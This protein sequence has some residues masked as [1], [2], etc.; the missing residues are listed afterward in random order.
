[1]EDI[2]TKG[3]RIVRLPNLFSKEMR[4]AILATIGALLICL[5]ATLTDRVFEPSYQPLPLVLSPLVPLGIGIA[6]ARFR[7]PL[8]VAIQAVVGVGVVSFVISRNHGSLPSDL[9]NGLFKGASAVFGTR[10]PVPAYPRAVALFALVVIVAAI[11][12]VEM[13]VSG[14][15]ASGVLLAPTALLA[16]VAL[17]ASKA[18]MPSPRFLVLFT[19]GN[20]AILRLSSLTRSDLPH[21]A[22]GSAQ[23]AERRSILTMAI[24]G[25]TAVSV[26]IVPAMLSG[27][28]S[29]NG[30]F[31]P[32]RGIRDSQSNEDEIS[33]LARVDVW[34]DLNPPLE[35][36]RT[37]ELSGQR[38]RIAGLSRYDGR[39]WM[40]S[41][42]F[43]L[44]GT[45][46]QEPDP[47]GLEPETITVTWG[48]LD[49]RWLP[50]LDHTRTLSVDRRVKVD[51]GLGGFLVADI[52]APQ[53]TYEL[54]VQRVTDDLSQLK[55]TFAQVSDDKVFV[56]GFE[57]PEALVEL[58]KG[59]VAG[60]E[61][62]I[63]RANALRDF[64]KKDY[65]LD[66]KVPS[67]HSLGVLSIFLQI[68]KRGR[69]EQFVAGY[70]L[71]AA[72]IGLPVRIAVGFE[73]KL[74]PDGT[75]SAAMSADATAWPEIDYVGTGWVPIDVVPQERQDTA[76]EGQQPV[77]QAPVDD[78]RPPPTT[79]SPPPTS[80]V[81]QPPISLA[82][83]AEGTIPNAAKK[84]IA[85]FG[86]LLLAILAY[87][88]VIFR[89]KSGRRRKRLEIDDPERRTT[90]A[91][92]TS[93]DTLID[94]GG[95][96]PVN[97]TD[98]ELVSIGAK[99]LP[100]QP[101]ALGDLAHIATQAVY[102]GEEP[103]DRLSSAAWE[104]HDAF[105]AQAQADAGRW[106]W[107]KA[108]MSLRSL[109]RG[110]PD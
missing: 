100:R 29:N 59:V 93:V 88:L 51:P 33:P 82:S 9:V 54:S 37:T 8:R 56:D 65:R 110:L 102:D 81:E 74:T 27:T 30:R 61:T 1:M 36:F 78:G 39:S 104:K 107:F 55:G 46:I 96:A 6:L 11:V 24:L 49:V 34:R 73:A 57:V 69:S 77:N 109:R 68:T 106:R 105:E 66:T 38:W 99:V 5:V 97:K 42:N 83:G 22:K 50:A 45:R 103:D 12:V 58:A 89:L 91:F 86:F 21:H 67:G 23:Q 95:R 79:V 60:A 108:R 14:K 98:R 43:Q 75:A 63:E 31:D 7:W 20:L 47:K 40:P 44:A 76:G 101:E 41:S 15:Y 80:A 25:I 10:W 32:R 70:A 62:D 53:D 2:W 35:M 72:A 19:L 26:G 13:A 71:L 85:G 64:L 94:L 90:G 4:L 48:N 87:V 28:L 18:G 3:G 16:F 52:P 92:R 17:S 84:A